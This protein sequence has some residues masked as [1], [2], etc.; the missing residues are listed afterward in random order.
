MNWDA[1]GAIGENI[2]A[3]AVVI[4]IIYLAV[5][6]RQNTKTLAA[7]TAQAVTDSAVDALMRVA[8]SHDLS[9]VAAKTFAGDKSLTGVEQMQ[10]QLVLR[11]LF[12]NFE[13]Y[14]YQHR[15]GY[16][17]DEIWA[18][19][20]LVIFDQLS[21]EAFREWWD[22]NSRLFGKSFVEFVNNEVLAGSPMQS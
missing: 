12:C 10:L 7:N 19:D 2:G 22:T 18:G 6:I 13:N 5:Q 20:K 15:R 17:E 1:I 4:S 16:F 11:S 14:F 21:T 9:S 3:F 8:E